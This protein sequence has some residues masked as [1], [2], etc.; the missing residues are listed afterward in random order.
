L[1]LCLALV[2][3][4]SAVLAAIV[5]AAAGMRVEPAGF[6]RFI[7]LALVMGA[8]AYWCR[9]RGLDRRLGAAAAIVGAATLSLM[10]CGVIANAGLRLGAPIA[11]ARLAAADAALGFDV[12]EI[13]REVAARPVLTEALSFLY[14]S[15]GLAV[16][17]LIG[18]AML[19]QSVAKGWELATTAFISMQL[20]ALTS[21]SFPALGA[22]RHFALEGLQGRGLPV[23]AGVYQWP[24]FT[25][26]YRGSDPMLRLSDMGG[27]VAFPSFHTVLALLIAQALAATRWRFAGVFWTA[28]IILSAIPMGGHYVVDLAAGFVIWLSAASIARRVTAQ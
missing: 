3:V 15:S 9:T 20:V 6:G 16:V 7:L 25:H 23:G 4:G 26:F 19:R 24:A 21:L 11:D 5:V 27:V 1:A 12:G 13:I 28:G 8:L 22:M 10:I 14:N 17:G 18:W 2:L